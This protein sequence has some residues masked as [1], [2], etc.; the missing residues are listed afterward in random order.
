MRLPP[1]PPFDNDSRPYP[2]TNIPLYQRLGL[3]LDS[4]IALDKRLTSLSKHHEVEE[5]VEIKLHKE[6]RIMLITQVVIGYH[7]LESRRESLEHARELIRSINDY[8]FGD[9]VDSYLV[10]RWVDDRSQSEGGYKRSFVVNRD[11]CRKNFQWMQYFRDG[12]L[13]ALI[14]DDRDSM[15]RIAAYPDDDLPQ[16]EIDF[17]P[18]D[19]AWRVLA[20][21]IV[22][23]RLHLARPISRTSSD[24]VEP[25]SPDSSWTR[26]EESRQAT[27]RWSRRA[28]SR[29]SS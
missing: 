8:L 15:R 25:G 9:W 20:G 23:G 4:D 5:G 3:D 10:T 16:R 21:S 17:G 2:M 12:L 6:I 13:W 29:A 19:M 14:L 22:L 18:P 26:S 11:W 1:E 28:S 24:G 7:I 27:R